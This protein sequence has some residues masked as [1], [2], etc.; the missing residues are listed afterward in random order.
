MTLKTAVPLYQ[1]AIL[2]GYLAHIAPGLPGGTATPPVDDR[3]LGE[4][5]TGTAGL[6]GGSTLKRGN[7]GTMEQSK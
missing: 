1:L 4:P 2:L 6:N 5:S 3:G 7:S